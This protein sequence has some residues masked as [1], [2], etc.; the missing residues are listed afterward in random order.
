MDVPGHQSRR[1]PNRHARFAIGIH[2]CLGS[3][4]ARAI[5]REVL[6]AV[7]VRMKGYAIDHEHVVANPNISSSRGYAIIPVTFTPGPGLGSGVEE[8]LIAP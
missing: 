2:R 1:F 8:D 5:F 6:P 4:L 3:N 7:L